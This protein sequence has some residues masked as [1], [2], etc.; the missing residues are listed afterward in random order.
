[1]TIG[2]SVDFILQYISFVI[3]R[4]EWDFIYIVGVNEMIVTTNSTHIVPSLFST[5]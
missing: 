3:Q 5:Q 4:G 1:M 2:Q